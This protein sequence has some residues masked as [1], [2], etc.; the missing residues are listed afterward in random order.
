[1]RKNAEPNSINDENTKAPNDESIKTYNTNNVEGTFGPIK[2][3]KGT[4][5]I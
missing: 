3:A 2:H 1:M 5:L 4:K